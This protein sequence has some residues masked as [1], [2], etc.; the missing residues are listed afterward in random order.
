MD[1]KG[2]GVIAGT[3]R[4][5]LA[6]AVRPTASVTT[7]DTVNGRGNLRFNLGVVLD[8]TPN[9]HVLLSAGRSL[10]GDTLFQAYAGYLF[11]I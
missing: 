1:L 11:T 10:W 2:E 9:H 8:L 5:E 3:G 6:D 7:A 4:P